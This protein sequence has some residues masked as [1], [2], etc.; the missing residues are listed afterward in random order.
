MQTLNKN[1]ER[2]YSVFASRIFFY[3]IVA[4]LI[5]SACWIA[6]TAHYPMA[7]DEDFH[8][9]IIKLYA[10]HPS[11]FWSQHPAQGDAFGAIARDPSYLFHYLMSF[12]YRFIGLFTHNQT[13]Q[14]LGLR[15]INIALFASCLPIFRRLLLRAGASPA[16]ANACLALFILIPITPF[17]AAQ[18]NYDNLIL[19]I[20][21]LLLLL[22]LKVSEKRGGE[23]VVLLLQIAGLGLAGSITKYAFLPIFMAVV[24]WLSFKLKV[25]QLRLRDLRHLKVLKTHANALLVVAVLVLSILSAERYLVN[26][27][28]YHNPIPK[29]DQVLNLEHCKSYGPFIRDYNF[30]AAKPVVDANPLAY[31]RHWFYGMWF[32]SFFALDG[33]RSSFETRGP[34][35]V[36]SVTAIIL[37]SIGGISLLMRA[38]K[39]YKL[40]PESTGLFLSVTALYVAALWQQEYKEYL[41]TGLPVAINGRYLLLII[42]PLMFV[43][44]SAFNLVLKDNRNL[45]VAILAISLVLIGSSGGALTYILRSND[46]WYWDNNITQSANHVVKRV[47]GPITPGINNPTAFLH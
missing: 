39:L 5:L 42:I 31:S 40:Y 41:Y 20:I 18:I 4:T 46:H 43:M 17:L 30:A 26:L 16:I 44:V 37:I 1:L 8:L 45:K 35:V 24:V 33:S 3:A 47:L 10:S 25:W 38:G 28:Q 34:F 15:A 36:P 22:A 11:P 19:P 27:V 12:P 2:L 21:G 13:I 32:R 23:R 9:G 7:F 14:V 6:L 29:C